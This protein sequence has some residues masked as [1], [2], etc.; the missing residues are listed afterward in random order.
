MPFRAISPSAIH[1]L[2]AVEC[3]Q[4]KKGSGN[5]DPHRNQHPRHVPCLQEKETITAILKRQP[6][7]SFFHQPR[8]A[9]HL[10]AFFL[11]Q[12]I[13]S[14]VTAHLENIAIYRKFKKAD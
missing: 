5:A 3:S 4:D 11:L 6:V 9:M 2:N 7:Q 1:N 13:V 8:A 10:Y 14:G 12:H